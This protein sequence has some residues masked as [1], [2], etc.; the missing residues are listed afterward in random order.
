M[1]FDKLLSKKYMP[2]LLLF[3]AA[4]MVY[5]LI[6]IFSEGFHPS[7]HNWYNNYSRQAHSW[8][9]GRLDLPE[10]RVYLEI[11]F[12]EGRN[13]I[14]FPPFPSVVLLPL[15]TLFGDTTPDHWVAL[16]FAL[17][18]LV[19]AYKLGE[20]VLKDKKYAMFFSL[21]LILGTNYL[22]LSLWG[23]VWY[24]AQ[25]MAFAFTLMAFYFALTDS[26]RHAILSLLALCAA[27]GCRPFNAIYLPLVLYL[28]YQREGLSF[29][30]FSRRLILY[31]VPAI[32]LGAFY[33]WLN[34]ARFGSVF[35]FGHNYLPEFVR[36]YHGQFHPSRILEN[37]RM[38]FLEL[39]ITYGIRN[40]FPFHGPGTSFAFWLASPMV[41]SYV[42]YLVIRYRSKPKG[43]RDVTIWLIPLLVCLHLFAFLFHRTLGGRQYGS[44]YAAD[45]LPAIYLGLL[46]ILSKLRLTNRTYLMNSVPMMFGLLTNFYG[47]IIFFTFYFG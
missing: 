19:F 26:K 39:D 36:D 44:R 35:E 42:V 22:H 3:A 47:T 11:A 17:V 20:L 31:A 24:L 30:R 5:G 27:M 29:F 23:A 41:I 34:Y 13:Y 18:S 4:L 16:V 14:S 2:Y 7:A 46:F 6:Y 45:S 1:D 33:M 10:N 32:V 21:F 25:N 28:L 43:E 15:V 9:Q 12:F 8:L 37:F 38:M 40:G